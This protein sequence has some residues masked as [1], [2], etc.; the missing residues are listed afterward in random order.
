MQQVNFEENH[1]LIVKKLKSW[2]K[3]WNTDHPNDQIATDGMLWADTA[4]RIEQA[5]SNQGSTPST[6]SA[7][8]SKTVIVTEIVPWADCTCWIKWEDWTFQKIEV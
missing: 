6:T 1:D 4:A 2:Q 8:A 5:A 3:Q 7:W